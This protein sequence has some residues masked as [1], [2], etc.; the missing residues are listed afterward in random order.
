MTVFQN[1][2]FGLR[3][4]DIAKAEARRMVEET[5]R[6]L[7]IDH[8]LDRKP[9]ALSGGERQRVALGRAVVRRP[10]VFLLDEPLSS[11]DAPLRAAM[12]S[13]IKDL[14]RKLGT[15]MIYVT[16]DQEEAMMLGD[17]LAV[18]RDGVLQQ[19]GAPMDVYQRP[20]NCFVAGFF[21]DP[22]M[23]LLS[24]LVDRSEGSA[25]FRGSDGMYEVRPDDSHG[26]PFGDRSEIVMGIRPEHVAIRWADVQRGRCAAGPLAGPK[27]VPEES[28]R[29][30]VRLAKEFRVAELEPR[31][32]TI[33]V[34]LTSETG[35]PLVATLPPEPLP[36]MGTCVEAYL[37]A[38]RLHWFESSA[39]T[40][41][42]S[43]LPP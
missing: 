10:R 21:G 12:R 4:R 2:A 17:R 16:H 37:D 38:S 39:Q 15:T 3:M 24:G 31:G 6:Q 25:I 27:Y 23:N 8:L 30:F 7:G 40:C 34:R 20:A 13:E 19:V 14:Q 42:R 5:A 9:N 35:T 22:P 41:F 28:N 29:R 1:M 11:L 32:A 18:L 33:R 43:E 26:L 36:R